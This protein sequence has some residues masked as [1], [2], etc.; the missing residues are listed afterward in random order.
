[1]TNE[2]L[3]SFWRVWFGPNVV[4][5]HQAKAQAQSELRDRFAAAALT[6]MHVKNNYHSGIST[7]QERARL[8]FIDADA[9]MEEREKR[10]QT[11][12]KARDHD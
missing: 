6:G 5:Q 2:Q 12:M 7:P 1:M 9:M 10:N 4:E 11:D 3:A 8:A